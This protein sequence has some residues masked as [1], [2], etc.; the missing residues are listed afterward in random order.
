[1]RTGSI[2]VTS[3]ESLRTDSICPGLCAPDTPPERIIKLRKR[4]CRLEVCFTRDELSELTK[5]AQKA[6]LSIGAFVRHM[7][8]NVQIKEAPPADFPVLIREVRRVGSNI[9][10]LI[11]TANAKGVLDV[12]QLR[13]VLEQNRAVEKM[14]WDTFT[15][16]Y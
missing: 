10:Q 8:R 1:M 13:R 4:N 2:V 16:S 9:D 3:N 15:T 14:L 6:H 12:S 5:K 7:V 11:L